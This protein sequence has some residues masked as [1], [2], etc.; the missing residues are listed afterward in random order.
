MIVELTEQK[1]ETNSSAKAIEFTATQTGILQMID[2]V[3]NK[4]YQNPIKSVMIEYVQNALDSHDQ[5]GNPETPIEITIPSEDYPFFEV[6]D[7]GISMSN[8][9]ISSIISKIGLSTK[10]GSNDLRGGFGLGKLVFCA[11]H[12][13]TMQLSNFYNGYRNDWMAHLSGGK[14]S[15]QPMGKAKSSEESGLLI[16]IQVNKSDIDTFQ[17]YSKTLYSY[18]TVKPIIKNYNDH[19][20][21]EDPVIDGVDEDWKIIQ[22]NTSVGI[23]VMGGLSYPIE[24]GN[25]KN[26]D[27]KFKSILNG[28][29]SQTM[30]LYFNIG[31]LDITSSR[32]S[33]DY[34]SEKTNNN[35]CE[36]IEKVKEHYE[37]VYSKFDTLTV[38][39]RKHIIRELKKEKGKN[40]LTSYFSCGFLNTQTVKDFLEKYPTQIDLSEAKWDSDGNNLPVVYTIGYGTHIHRGPNRGTSRFK[41]YTGTE[42][43]RPTT[44][45]MYSTRYFALTNK[46]LANRRF[47]QIMNN[48][49]AIDKWDNQKYPCIIGRTRDDIIKFL[50]DNYILESDVIFLDDYEKELKKSKGASSNVTPHKVYEVGTFGQHSLQ[51]R[52]K[53]YLDIIE[54]DPDEYP[55]T[56]DDIYY[57]RF[58][59]WDLDNDRQMGQIIRDSI[60][61]DI[62]KKEDTPTLLAFN[63]LAEKKHKPENTYKHINEYLKELKKQIQDKMDKKS[64]EAYEF[65]LSQAYSGISWE[66]KNMLERIQD[67]IKNPTIAYIMNIVTSSPNR[68]NSTLSGHSRYQEFYENANTWIGNVLTEMGLND[69]REFLNQAFLEKINNNQ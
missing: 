54:Y 55:N 20:F 62:I 29:G 18:M 5:K 32:D 14:G 7:F 1:V 65:A 51:Y 23:A 4:Q 17:G 44:F 30:V 42:Y 60:N 28:Y 21:I 6:R 27:S 16:K 45:P 25:I 22:R 19:E 31:E 56:D 46:N 11:Y 34:G 68:N 53:E 47:G 8:S 35:I 64:N 59:M 48:T 67:D 36:K 3:A 33:L 58:S 10:N 69:Y 43:G 63:S 49:S 24:W 26:L 2:V 37:V 15:V 9:E 61:L 40:T 39:E 50:K 52:A 12:T 66:I 13:K 38:Y 41:F 57:V